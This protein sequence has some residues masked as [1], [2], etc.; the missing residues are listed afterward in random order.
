MEATAFRS[1]SR[2]LKNLWIDAEGQNPSI[3]PDACEAGMDTPL[4]EGPGWPYT[5]S[6]AGPSGG[7]ADALA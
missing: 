3:M 6:S 2:R 1:S 5:L 4:N 7:M